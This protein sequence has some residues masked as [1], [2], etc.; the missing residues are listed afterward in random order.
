MG[1]ALRDEPYQVRQL[2]TAPCFDLSLVSLLLQEVSP[3]LSR[4]VS[5]NLPDTS[6]KLYLGIARQLK[7]A[8]ARKRKPW[9]VYDAMVVTNRASSTL[10]RAFSFMQDQGLIVEINIAGTQRRHY[11]FT[12]KDI[13]HEE[14]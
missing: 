2:G 6:R 8:M 4:R 3:L 7:A 12:Q 9:N 5:P 1:A 10:R 14:V 13:P 11:K